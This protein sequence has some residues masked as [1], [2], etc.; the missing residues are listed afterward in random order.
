MGQFER[1]GFARMPP[2]PLLG[3]KLD[4][5]QRN[6]DRLALALLADNLDAVGRTIARC[7]IHD[8][9]FADA[10]P[11]GLFAMPLKP[12]TG[13]GQGFPIEQSTTRANDPVGEVTTGTLDD[14]ACFER[15]GGR[16]PID[17]EDWHNR[18][19]GFGRIERKIHGDVSV[20][21]ANN[22]H[23]VV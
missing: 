4:A 3:R 7:H 19:G 21:Q 14:V 11:T 16:I 10:T 17:V 18:L 15:M 1:G 20:A 9:L 23:S 12:T 22:D 5:V 13:P 8:E 2:L 6:G